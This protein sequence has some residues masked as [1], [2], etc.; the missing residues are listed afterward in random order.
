M[1]ND[2][3][4]QH[5]DPIQHFPRPLLAPDGNDRHDVHASPEQ[6]APD[7]TGGAAI[8]TVLAPGKD[9][10]ADETDAHRLAGLGW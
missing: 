6:F 5:G 4:A 9:L 10:H 2:G 3:E 7:D 8:A 1:V